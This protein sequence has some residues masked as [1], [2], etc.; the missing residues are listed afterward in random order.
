MVGMVGKGDHQSKEARERISAAR[1]GKYTGEK[2]PFF[3][4]RH[5]PEAIEKMR[6]AKLGKIPW[7][8]GRTGENS[9]MT[10]R[11]V[12][13]ETRRKLSKAGKGKLHPWQV[14]ENNPTKRPEVR[15]KISATKMG[16][17]RPDMAGERN[18][19]YGGGERSSNWRG[20][21][22]FEPYCPKFNKE[23]KERVRAFWGYAC[24]NCGKTQSENI[25]KSGKVQKLHVHHVNYRKDACC[26]EEVA[27]QFI[28]LCSSCHPRTNHDRKK[29][30]KKISRL[31]EKKFGGRCYFHQGEQLAA[32]GVS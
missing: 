20:G 14:G 31:I 32:Y 3:G 10:G 16:V 2:N 21:I 17:P 30:E 7:N 6:K 1:R 18:P 23:F 24:G 11:L 26:E 22:S 15:A 8:K 25:T 19:N 5:S 28:P 4:K 29:W 27:R 13:S 12:S 9:P